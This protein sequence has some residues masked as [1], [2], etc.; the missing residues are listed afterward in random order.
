L[1]YAVCVDEPKSLSDELFERVLIEA[2]RMGAIPA[3]A[4]EAAQ[5]HFDHVARQAAG[6]SAVDRPAALSLMA[7][8]IV[9][10]AQAPSIGDFHA[11]YRR[12]QMRARAQMGA[13]PTKDG[14]PE[15]P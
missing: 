7:A 11:D 2:V 14:P 15:P 10:E 4:V 8:Q 1:S 6:S 5:T 9:M 12:R 3:A 13:A